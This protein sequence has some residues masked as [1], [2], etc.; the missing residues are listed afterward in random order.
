[1]AR[2][3]GR[4]KQRR[5]ERKAARE[6]FR[7]AAAEMGMSRFEFAQSLDNEDEDSW[8]A[9]ALVSEDRP[10]VID[11]ERLIELIM[12]IIKMIMTFFSM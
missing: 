8:A 7:E 5:A 6:A 12:A 10:E 4:L 9:V 1:M 2:R 11:I 3:D